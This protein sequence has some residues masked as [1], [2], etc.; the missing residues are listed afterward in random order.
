MIMTRMV[1]EI[2]AFMVAGLASPTLSTMS[3]GI[4]PIATLAWRP[5]LDPLDAHD[6]WWWFLLPLAFG[7]SV[8]Y[9]AIRLPSMRRFWWQAMRMGV[10][11]VAVMIALSIILYIIVEQVAP[12]M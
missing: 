4:D 2:F 9:K 11:I 6:L 12:R 5:F 1:M 10:Q 3:A 7:V 8:V